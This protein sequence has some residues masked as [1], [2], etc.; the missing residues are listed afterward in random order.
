MN[1]AFTLFLTFFALIPTLYSRLPCPAGKVY[2][3]DSKSCLQSC[4]SSYYVTYDDDGSICSSKTIIETRLRPV[5]QEQTF[6]LS[7]FGS[8]APFTTTDQLLGNISLIINSDSNDKKYTQVVNKTAARFLGDDF[9]TV[10]LFIDIESMPLDVE[11]TLSFPSYPIDD[12]SQFFA[13]LPYQLQPPGY[14]SSAKFISALSKLDFALEITWT[15]LTLMNPYAFLYMNAK[16]YRET[17]DMFKHLGVNNE[18]FITKFFK[19]NNNKVSGIKIPNPLAKWLYNNTITSGWISSEEIMKD[20]TTLPQDRIEDLRMSTFE[21]YERY[22]PYTLF[23]DNYGI[24]IALLIISLAIAIILELVHLI[25][26]KIT[27]DTIPK[28]RVFQIFQIIR[29]TFRWNICIAIIIGSY[30]SLCFYTLVQFRAFFSRYNTKNFHNTMG[31]LFCVLTFLAFGV[32]FPTFL[33]RRLRQITHLKKNRTSQ[34]ENSQYK[35]LCNY[36]AIFCKFFNIDRSYYP[37]YIPVLLGR[38]FIFAIMT[39]FADNDA[40]IQISFMIG[41]SIA[42]LVYFLI[43]WPY[44]LFIY[45]LLQCIYEALLFAMLSVLLL[46]S[47]A[48]TSDAG[49]LRRDIISYFILVIWLMI[50]LISTIS[51]AVGFGYVIFGKGMN[52][53][54]RV[55]PIAPETEP[56]IEVTE[57]NQNKE[58]EKEERASSP[59]IIS[60]SRSLLASATTNTTTVKSI[61]LPHSEYRLN[62]PSIEEVM[63]ENDEEKEGEKDL[64][65]FDLE[66]G[67]IETM[68]TNRRFDGLSSGFTEDD[69]KQEIVRPTLITIESRKYF[70]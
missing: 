65:V 12:T 59:T 55:V 47:T 69:R 61:H 70:F 32:I 63:S 27:K 40:N 44:R 2:F 48:D 29:I 50:P 26:M 36:Y 52:S 15:T 45:N 24:Q 35:A 7:F 64:Q 41:T 17:F 10:E 31:F 19:N 56:A 68:E 21:E 38:S 33:V 49:N 8:F 34:I 1:A 25:I 39:V 54:N 57:E 3:P 23:L 51:G 14:T 53:N 20:Y 58:K 22:Q 13:V 16:L 30:Q 66:D 46:F 18:P 37:I 5:P 11:L 9:Y 4:P 62:I 60:S 67:A 6:I 43:V 42:F 28:S